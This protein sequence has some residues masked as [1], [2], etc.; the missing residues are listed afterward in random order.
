VLSSDR[1]VSKWIEGVIA[2][3]KN[4]IVVLKTFPLNLK[5]QF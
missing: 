3:T 1:N 2:P 4:E 5:Q